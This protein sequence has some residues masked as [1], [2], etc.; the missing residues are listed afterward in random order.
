MIQ[1]YY[2]FGKGKTTAALG[3][4]VR[5][6]GAGKSACVYAFLKDNSSSERFANCD[7]DF[8]PTPQKLPF[9][10]KMSDA[11]KAEYA[12]FAQ[13]MLSDALSSNYDVIVLD[14]LL[15]AV[16]LFDSD[17]IKSL[18]FSPDKEYVITGHTK[19]EPLFEK[20]DY[21][22][23]FKKIRHPYDNG[24]SARRGIEF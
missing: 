5:A 11:E 21:I 2:G 9:L 16:S 18:S 12:A 15:D 19:I 3:Q 7:V 13:K 8:Y 10:F 6:C 1:I 17:Y 22:T 20:A 24:V 14:E 23:E 4:A